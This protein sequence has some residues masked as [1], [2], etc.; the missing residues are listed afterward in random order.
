MVE[1]RVLALPQ[2]GR[3]VRMGRT[4]LLVQAVFGVLIVLFSVSRH[5]WLS[6]LL[7]FCAAS[8]FRPASSIFRPM[9]SS[10][11][12]GESLPKVAAPEPPPD[13]APIMPAP[14]VRATMPPDMREM[15]TPIAMAQ[16]TTTAV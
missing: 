9:S 10:L 16:M 7:L 15:T 8:I 13:M 6:R 12:I 14:P 3:F 5:L 1:R 2:L 4:L 11:P